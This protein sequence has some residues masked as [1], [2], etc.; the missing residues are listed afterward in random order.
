[1]FDPQKCVEPTSVPF[2]WTAKSIDGRDKR[3]D[4]LRKKYA[5]SDGHAEVISGSGFLSYVIRVVFTF[6]GTDERFSAILKVPT[7]QKIRDAK[8]FAGRDDVFENYLFKLHNQEILFYKEIA[9]KCD[10]FYF[11]K[12]YAYVLSD[13]K[14]GAHGRILMEDVGDRGTLPDIL[15][16][17]KYEQCAEAIK[18]LARFHAFGYLH[19]TDDFLRQLRLCQTERKDEERLQLSPAIFRLDPYFAE[20][21]TLLKRIEADYGKIMID[22]HLHFGIP[23]V[24]THGDFWGNNMFFEKNADGSSSDRVFTIFD[25]QC[26]RPDSG[27]PDVTKF[28]AVSASESV[29]REK[30]PN[31]LALYYEEMKQSLK[32]NGVVIPYDFENL[33]A[34]YEHAFPNDLLFSLMVLPA[35]LQ[36]VED[37]K[38]IAGVVNRLKLNL[39]YVVKCME[40]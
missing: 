14:A 28:L 21:M 26:L 15:Q 9:E 33:N 17:L 38:I 35:L 24:L 18:V 3:W 27:I 31:L 19:A 25:W 34:M 11:P 16:G 8:M 10:I 23:P 22:Q 4:R 7:V 32:E 1:M 40:K 37:E 12:M 13:G 39:E 30:I 2:G 6:H 29:L 20:N 36:N 5:L